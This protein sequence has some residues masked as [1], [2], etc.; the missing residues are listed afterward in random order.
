M[1]KLV[2]IVILISITLNLLAIPVSAIESHTYYYH[3][4]QIGSVIAVS[5]ENGNLIQQSK[6]LPYGNLSST[7]N[8][9][10]TTNNQ[11]RS[12]TNQIKDKST[13]LLY[14][15]ARYYD[16]TLGRFISA[17][18]TNDQQNRYNYV[19]GN[20]IM[21]NDP[22]GKKQEDNCK[23]LECLKDKLK[24]IFP[25]I[26]NYISLGFYQ[27]TN[28]NGKG[29]STSKSLSKI[30]DNMFFSGEDMTLDLIPAT[31]SCNGNTSCVT[32]SLKASAEYHTLAAGAD[33]LGTRPLA[34]KFMDRF[35]DQYNSDYE[36]SK[37]EAD[38]IFN[39]VL[40]DRLATGEKITPGLLVEFAGYD[41]YRKNNHSTVHFND[42]SILMHTIDPDLN[43]A[44]NRFTASFTG[45]MIIE[46]NKVDEYSVTVQGTLRNIFD[47][48]DWHDKNNSSDIPGIL[49]QE[50]GLGKPFNISSSSEYTYQVNKPFSIFVPVQ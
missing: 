31:A 28:T 7:Y 3:T 34:T 24:S 38:T 49:L 30:L 47:T 36:L 26:K 6:Y 8:S 29:I 39:S 15:N 10:P 25:E 18:S 5:D 2:S 35:L 12:Y 17:D 22:G 27:F 11:E 21:R 42:Q 23:G 50:N 44:L 32:N 46:Q 1:K 41:F 14:Y 45:D 4:D 43:V 48:Y 40:S 33:I 9:Q 16:P 37:E 20:P 19:G 13:S